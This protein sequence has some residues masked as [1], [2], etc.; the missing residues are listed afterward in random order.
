MPRRTSPN[1]FYFMVCVVHLMVAVKEISNRRKFDYKNSLRTTY[2]MNGWESYQCDG[3]ELLTYSERPLASSVAHCSNYESLAS[4]QALNSKQPNLVPLERITYE[5]S[6]EARLSVQLQTV[7]HNF[8]PF[9]F[10]CEMIR[11]FTA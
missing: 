2:L 10:Q 5:E 8:A 7:S 11:M 4:N 9:L 6:R 3:K 1:I